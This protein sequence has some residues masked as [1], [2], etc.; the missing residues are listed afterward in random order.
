[1]TP[2]EWDALF[3]VVIGVAP[4]RTWESTTPTTDWEIQRD[5]SNYFDKLYCSEL[6]IKY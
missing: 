6:G 2:E 3:S 5:A 4:W 1:M